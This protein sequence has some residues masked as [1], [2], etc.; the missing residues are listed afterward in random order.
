M[1]DLTQTKH[2]DFDPIIDREPL[3]L[4][5]GERIAVIPFINIEHFPAAIAGTALTSATTSLT[6]DPLN[7]GWRDYGMRVGLWRLMDLLD[8][9]GMRATVCLN[10]EVIQEYPQIIEEGEKRCWAWMGHGVNNA[11]SNLICNPRNDD[12]SVSY[13]SEDDERSILEASLESMKASLNHKIKGWLSPYLTH[14]DNTP[15]LLEELGVEYLCDYTADDHPFR[16]N[17]P[18]KNL[19]SVPYTL[20]LNDFPAFLNI[21]VSAKDFGDMI[22][23]H[24]DVLYEEG[25]ANARCMPICLHTFLVGQPNKAKH[26]RRAFDYITSHEDVWLATGDEIN[27]WYRTSYM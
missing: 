20:E 26:I 21:G 15:R 12:G 5:R 13:L 25:A 17:T 10:S 4:P 27:D 14:T 3:K 11:P 23:D 22:I 18:K 6:P 7:Y 8:T 16:F 2:Y 24:F 9:F 19:I 1:P